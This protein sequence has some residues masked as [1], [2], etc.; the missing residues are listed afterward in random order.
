[1]KRLISGRTQLMTLLLLLAILCNLRW[2]GCSIRKPQM[3]SWD[4]TWDLPLINRTYGIAELLDKLNNSSISYDTSGN[5]GIDITKNLDTISVDNN[6]KINGMQLDLRDSVGSV[7]VQAPDDIYSNTLLS[8]IVD[9]GMGFVPPASFTFG[10]PLPTFTRFT[11]A[12]IDSGAMSVTFFNNMEI[13]LDTLIVTVMDS[14]DMHVVGVIACDN[15]LRYLETETQTLDIAGQ[16]ISNTLLLQYHGHTPGGVLINAGPENL[17]ATASFPGNLKVSA[18]R[19]EVLEIVRTKSQIYNIEDSTKVNSSIISQGIIQFNILN[20]TE[21]PFTITLHSANFIINGAEFQMTQPLTPNGQT[22]LSVNLAGYNFIPSNGDTNQ[23]VLIDMVNHI[24]GSAPSQYTFRAADSLL[25]HIDISDI[26]FQTL[27]G[28]IEPSI[29]NINPIQANIDLP[30]GIDRSTLNRARMIFNF[31]N[32]SMVPANLNLTVEGGGKSIPISGRIAPKRS[33]DDP[34]Q[35]TTLILGPEDLTEFLN[36]PPAEI[37]MSGYALINP[38]YEIITITPNDGFYGDIEFV[39]P[40]AMV[41]GDTVSIFPGITHT[42]ID[43]NSRPKDFE[44]TAKSGKFYGVLQ[45]DL[46]LGIKISFYIGTESDSALYGNG[47]TLKLGPYLLSAAAVD[48][49]GQVT[50]PVSSDFSDSL[51]TDELAVFNHDRIYIAEKV[52]IMPTDSNG[53]LISGLNSLKIRGM[54]RMQLHVGDNIWK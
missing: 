39:S 33:P 15:G 11:W 23:T 32:N 37:S 47:S 4:T 3:P 27:T 41:F 18:A 17:E 2:S 30:M 20:Q 13:D 49:S 36:P 53:V 50:T 16:T 14:A 44:N 6:L 26:H 52:D 43:P 46:P 34:P 51:T 9:V 28:R 54:A 10:Q 19:A 38:D 21:L 24:P 42:D 8:S 5:P 12:T 35:L 25:V 1:M 7:E 45:N 48:S 22:Q 31:Y 29:Q 40:L